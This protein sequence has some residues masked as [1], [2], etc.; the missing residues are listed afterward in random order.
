MLAA[1]DAGIWIATDVDESELPPWRFFVV[2]PFLAA[3]REVEERMIAFRAHEGQA[4]LA[5][6]VESEAFPR[7]LDT[8]TL[9]DTEHAPTLDSLREPVRSYIAAVALLGTRIRLDVV[10]AFFRQLM[11]GS[12]ADELTV[13][14]ITSID[15]G[16]LV[17]SSD[18]IRVAA[19][20][21]IPSSSRP[22]LCRVA[23]DVVVETTGDLTGAAAL[24]IDA[25]DARAASALLEQV[26]FVSNDKA[27]WLLRA[28]PRQALTPKLAQTLAS[29]LIDNGRYRDARDVV[30]VLTAD[31]RELLLARIERRTGDYG[32]ALARLDR[33][34]SRTFDHDILRAELLY[35]ESRY[36]DMRHALAACTARERRGRCSPRLPRRI[37]GAR[38]GRGERSC[39]QC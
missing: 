19:K 37:A 29:A 24:L 7:F 28:M 4:W 38:N 21:L 11:F 15:D 16:H 39:E 2:A 33:I 18:A 5:Q 27:L 13:D 36:D 1:T 34:A 31:A 12:V 26:T 25:G 20:N 30:L 17:F 14:G 10:S 32:P 22:T 3:R 6:L 35:L 9:P 8:G 23:A